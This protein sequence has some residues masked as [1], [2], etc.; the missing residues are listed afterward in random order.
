MSTVPINSYLRI[1]VQLS[2]ENVIPTL[3]N[4][5]FSNIIASKSLITSLKISVDKVFLSGN[6]I[7]ELRNLKSSTTS[8]LFI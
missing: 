3:S 4:T 1:L 2:N 7:C 5:N 8:G 6:F